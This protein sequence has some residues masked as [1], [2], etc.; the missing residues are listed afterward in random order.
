MNYLGGVEAFE[1]AL[2]TTP[3]HFSATYE[4]YFYSNGSIRPILPPQMSLET[5]FGVVPRTGILVGNTGRAFRGALDHAFYEYYLRPLVAYTI[6]GDFIHSDQVYFSNNNG[7]I[8]MGG[9]GYDPDLYLGDLYSGQIIESTTT[10]YHDWWGLH[11]HP[12]T[13][14]K[15]MD[16]VTGEDGVWIPEGR[17][18]GLGVGAEL[19]WDLMSMFYELKA[20]TPI[21]AQNVIHYFQAEIENDVAAYRFD[22]LAKRT[23]EK[24]LPA[25]TDLSRIAGVVRLSGGPGT[26]DITVNVVDNSGANVEVKKQVLGLAEYGFENSELASLPD[27]ITHDDVASA[28]VRSHKELEIGVINQ[29]IDGSKSSASVEVSVDQVQHTYRLHDH[30]F[31]RDNP[32]GNKN[33][34]EAVSD[35]PSNTNRTV[36][37]RLQAFVGRGQQLLGGPGTSTATFSLD[38]LDALLN[39]PKFVTMVNRGD[40][41]TAAVQTALRSLRDFLTLVSVNNELQA[42]GYTF[43]GD[44]ALKVYE[45]NTPPLDRVTQYEYSQQ[46]WDPA[47][48]AKASE[49][50]NRTGQFVNRLE[51][52]QPADLKTNDLDNARSTRSLRDIKYTIN[53][54]VYSAQQLGGNALAGNQVAME[55]AYIAQVDNF[56]HAYYTYS[57]YGVFG[58]EA[59]L[60]QKPGDGGKL[61]AVAIRRLNE[62]DAHPVFENELLENGIYLTPANWK[63]YADAAGTSLGDEPFTDANVQ[64]LIESF[65]Q[66]LRPDRSAHEFGIQLPII[67]GLRLNTGLTDSLGRTIFDSTDIK[68]VQDDAGFYLPDTINIL[69]TQTE[70]IEVPASFV[71]EK[72]EYQYELSALPSLPVRVT[73]ADVQSALEAASASRKPGILD[74]LIDGTE[75]A[76]TVTITVDDEP[77]TVDVPAAY[78]SGSAPTRFT[79]TYD[80]VLGVNEHGLWFGSFEDVTLNVNSS[81]HDHDNDPATP[82]VSR[83]IDDVVTI[84]GTHFID[85]LEVN[86]GDGNNLVNVSGLGAETQINAGV[87]DDEFY[88]HSL[89]N[90][91]TINANDGDDQFY[92]NY[93][94]SIDP[95]PGPPEQTFLNGVTGT[96]NVHGQA[97]TDIYEIGLSGLGHAVINVIDQSNGDLGLDKLTVY[98]T[99]ENDYYLFRPGVIAGIEVDAEE[100]PLIGGVVERINYDG[101]INAG[102]VVNGRDGDDTFVLDDTNAALEINGDRGNDTFQV[103]Q[104]FQSARDALANLPAIDQFPTTQ[105]T[106]GFLS[107][108]VSQPATLNGGDGED[109]FTVF[110]N[111]AEISLNGDADNDTF[112]LR[113]F[114][115]VDPNDPKAPITNVN[116]GQGADFISFTVNAPVNI[117]GGDGL[118][119]LT[120]IGTELGDDFV[121]QAAGI[122]GAGRFTRFN[123]VEKVVID[124]IAGNDTFF[125][126]STSEDVDLEVIGGLG[127]DQFN[128]GGSNDAPVVVVANDLNGHSGLINHVI[129][130]STPSTTEFRPELSKSISVNIGDNEEAEVLIRP[131]DGP[132]RVFEQDLTDI[133]AAIENGFLSYS[134]TVV[135]TRAPEE[136]VRITASPSQPTEASLLAGAEGIS[137]AVVPAGTTP[138]HDL[139]GSTLGATLLFTRENWFEEQTVV[140]TAPDEIT[141]SLVDGVFDNRAFY[142][143]RHSVT[144]GINSDDGDQYDG[145]SVASLKAEVID[146]QSPQVVIA[147]SQGKTRVA[148]LGVDE[149]TSQQ[150]GNESLLRNWDE[151]HVVLSMEPARDE[152]VAIDISTDGQVQVATGTTATASD[153]A[154]LTFDSDNWNTP[155][156]VTVTTSPDGQAEGKSFSRIQHEL[157]SDDA[158]GVYADVVDAGSVD[159]EVLDDTP[160]VL[161]TQDHDTTTVIEPTTNVSLGVG[162][163][164]DPVDSQSFIGNFG[165]PF[166]PEISGNDGLAVPQDL[167]AGDWSLAYN[168]N[169]GDL[170]EDDQLATTPNMSE[171]IPH[172]TVKATGDETADYFAFEVTQEMLDD[173]GGP[174]RLV[175]DLD[176]GYENGDSV[177]WN[178]TTR[179]LHLVEVAGNDVPTVLHESSDSDPEQDIGSSTFFDTFNDLTLN[180]AKTYYIEVTNEGSQGIPAGADYDLHISLEQ[181]PVAAFTFT[182][183]PVFEDE[184]ANNIAQDLDDSNA[185]NV[186]D[187][188]NFSQF[189]DPNIGNQAFGGAVNHRTPYT[190]IVGNGDG[191]LDVY[192]FEVT[193]EML[194]PA[195]G[196]I[197]SD[198]SDVDTRDYYESANLVLTP[199]EINSQDSAEGLWQ[200]TINGTT[201]SFT[202]DTASTLDDV[203][204]AFATQINNDPHAFVT[205]DATSPA[206]T[207]TLSLTDPRVDPATEANGFRVDSLTH[208]APLNVASQLTTSTAFTH[209]Q[210]VLEADPEDIV[211]GD[212]WTLR[213]GGD[214]YSHI[215]AEGDTLN[216]IA[217]Q[218]RGKIPRVSQSGRSRRRDHAR[219]DDQP[220]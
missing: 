78:V 118:D 112:V 60:P 5:M 189:F 184:L 73:H 143:I 144:E 87:G 181:H 59:I 150:P 205:F 111:L 176:N 30:L 187:P 49:F 141:P 16:H 67:D 130:S 171:E 89:S 160:S 159:V 196:T 161:I 97:G 110:H 163:V 129:E 35:L 106:K 27:G 88:I 148:E 98:G 93:E 154:T 213:V 156:R 75:T 185:D 79:T 100:N 52:G 64:A 99:D 170:T 50:N 21:E 115:R 199:N 202:G 77:V 220:S 204:A 47:T 211:V 92:V 82:D 217:G 191:T 102:I 69:R 210:V 177:F 22:R 108:G 188:N 3:D 173:N 13:F 31:V 127:S 36:L 2:L 201:Y 140:V 197:D 40:A 215:V 125:I 80:S 11:F 107:N 134:Y 124:A 166:L 194:N 131:T 137:L 182:P 24:T 29:L 155:Q 83:V 142:E 183:S 96:L 70:Q 85:E 42:E 212:K 12:F 219:F 39:D 136:D 32:T 133:P 167:D 153:T 20:P 122:F 41:G 44:G 214:E 128:V 158:D 76:T 165:R 169:V 37:N 209:A 15:Y 119:T 81:D 72:L 56:D 117:A 179:I 25:N 135:L 114:V 180:T 23:V 86:I 26:D 175:V 61:E 207:G 186:D 198:E 48:F 68:A 206:N 192:E 95:V 19:Y 71:H 178:P 139:I 34:A 113:S 138:S 66:T 145:L 65:G 28:L 38:S 94:P 74:R 63:G 7:E 162:Q 33:L 45:Q 152:T 9:W 116:G 1:H 216:D 174:L 43:S 101:D 120:I 4:H 62:T 6:W 126:Q 218:I 168:P 57:Y 17:Y 10:W 90:E 104:M 84:D 208:T 193:P 132:I 51:P 54:V 46:I 58:S 146:A 149:T 18:N 121:V 53:G 164:V 123:G 105:T 8:R 151:Y 103:G 200:A 147:E 195:G 190:S 91:T 109:L 157:S 55:N 14:H 172:L 203:T